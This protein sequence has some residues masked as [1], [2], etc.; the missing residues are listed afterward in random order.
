MKPKDIETSRE[1]DG[2]ESLLVI[3]ARVSVPH[4]WIL[5]LLFLVLTIVGVLLAK[6]VF[7][8]RSEAFGAYRWPAAFAIMAFYGFFEVV[9]AWLTGLAFYGRSELKVGRRSVSAITHVGPFGRLRRFAVGEMPRA[10]IAPT[11][12]EMNGEPQYGVYLYYGENP[13]DGFDSHP[14]NAFWAFRSFDHDSCLRV[15][16]MIVAELGRTSRR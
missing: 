9:I 4:R 10:A 5:L 7:G 14:R 11:G 13:Y 1:T 16:D 6:G 2:A 3:R 12:A 8:E 15:L